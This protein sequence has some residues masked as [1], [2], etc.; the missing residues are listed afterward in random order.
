MPWRHGAGCHPRW[1]RQPPAAEGP[2]GRGRH[3]RMALHDSTL[4]D[5]PEGLLH[6]KRPAVRDRIGH[7]QLLD[8]G[9][10]DT[11][12]EHLLIEPRRHDEVA[13]PER[14]EG[15]Q[16][17]DGG[18]RAVRASAANQTHQVYFVPHAGRTRGH[19]D[20]Q[21]GKSPLQV[22][23][24]DEGWITLDAQQVLRDR[25]LAGG[26]LLLHLSEDAEI[27]EVA[28]AMQYACGFYIAY[29]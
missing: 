5:T 15:V 2:D 24:Q 16:G 22:H 4:G 20:A 7:R 21:L 23:R 25:M 11:G 3:I 8:R 17:I 28:Q 19:K 27:R 9:N 6:D 13:G 1:G 26:V 14:T 12:S 29:I 18:G 10:Q